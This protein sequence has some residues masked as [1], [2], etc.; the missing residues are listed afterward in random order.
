MLLV[1]NL[2]SILPLK[3]VPGALKTITNTFPLEPVTNECSSPA[4]IVVK[5][6]GC[7]LS[8]VGDNLVNGFPPTV[9][10]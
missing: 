1:S 6:M 7:A 4:Y 10:P 3:V 8:K 5:T 9:V 2:V